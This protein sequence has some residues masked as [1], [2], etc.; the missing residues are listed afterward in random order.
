M[1]FTRLTLTSVAVLAMPPT[2]EELLQ[3]VE[4]LKS[5]NPI[6]NKD[7]TDLKAK[8]KDLERDVGESDNEKRAWQEEA[9]RLV[10]M[11]KEKDEG[12]DILMLMALDGDTYGAVSA[13]ENGLVGEV[14]EQM[15]GL[16]LEH[17]QMDTK[18]VETEDSSDFGDIEMEEEALQV[19]ICPDYHPTGHC[20]K[21]HPSGK[22][23]NG[24]HALGHRPEQD[25]ANF[26]GQ[27]VVERV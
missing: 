9:M 3:E 17:E 13:H 4:L 5:M 24:I 18:K 2:Y 10:R 16:E 6:L 8:I 14:T 1:A 15:D 25:S 7:K 12:N 19:Q 27:A 21:G 20:R 22:C 11:V 26:T 23:P